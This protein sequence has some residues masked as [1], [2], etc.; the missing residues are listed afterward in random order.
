[1]DYYN[2]I[3]FFVIGLAVGSFL[4]VII[5]RID[6]LK[7]VL[8]DRSHCPK[9]KK[10][11][12]W[13]D[14]IPFLSFML[15]RGR[16]RY[17]G[18]SISWQYPLVELGTGIVF[19]LLAINFGISASLIYL[20]ILFAILIIVFVYDLREQMV[21]EVFVWIAFALALVGGSYFGGF[22]ILESIIGGAFAGG[23]LWLLVLFSKE[24]WMGAGDIK[25]GFI[26]GFLCGYPSAL[27]ALFCAFFLGSVVG[28]IYL[29][30]TRKTIN[31]NGLRQSLPF[32]PFL[33]TSTLIFVLWGEKIINWYLGFYRI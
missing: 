4:N 31:R 10:T 32:A 12:A 21:P 2:Q 27:F 29:L 8:Y 1:M 18:K 7:T 3:L 17:C 14:L 20:L 15:L 16:C 19:W 22:T 30:I 5:L 11:I 13:Y 33:I 24:R 28:I 9:C 26:L 25:I 6:E 23:F